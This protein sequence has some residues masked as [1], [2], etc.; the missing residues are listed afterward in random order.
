MSDHLP[1]DLVTIPVA[2]GRLRVDP[3]TVHRWIGKGKLRAWRRAGTRRLVSMREV[4]GLIQPV[5][6]EV[7]RVDGRARK[8]RARQTQEVLRWAG[9]L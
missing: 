1:D 3:S 2:A 4:L 8:R 9:L 6:K 5:A 7:A